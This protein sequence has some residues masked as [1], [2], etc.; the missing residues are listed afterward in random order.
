MFMFICYNCNTCI[1]KHNIYAHACCI[2]GSMYDIIYES[3]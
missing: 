1:I 3:T 2:E